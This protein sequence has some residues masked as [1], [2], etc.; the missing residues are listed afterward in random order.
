VCLEGSFQDTVV[1]IPTVADDAKEETYTTVE[2]AASQQN[3]GFTL[4]SAV[5][6]A[7]GAF[8]WLV[9]CTGMCYESKCQRNSSTNE[10]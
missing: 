4:G 9:V 3:S 6:I 7:V 2:E 1:V 5:T 10:I 8:I